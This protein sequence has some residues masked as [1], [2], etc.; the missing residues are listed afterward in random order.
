MGMGGKAVSG[1]APARADDVARGIA[2]TLLAIFLFAT[3]D[4]ASKL[5]VQDHSPFQV[6]MMRFWAFCAMSVVL[7]RRKGPF[8]GFFRSRSPKLQVLRPLLLVVDIWLFMFALATVPLAELQ[9]ITL[10]YPLIVTLVAI[11]LLG[12]KVGVFRF[13]AV[14]AGFVGALVIVRPGGLPLDFGALCGLASAACYAVYLVLTRKVAAVDPTETSLI[15][16]GVIGLVLTSAV[17][18]FFWQTPDAPTLGLL[19]YIMFTGCAG[20]GLI[21]AAL[22]AAPASVLQPF[23]YTALPWGILFGY[24]VF[25]QMIDPVSLG[26]A[27][28]IVA[29]GLAVMMRERWKRTTAAGLGRERA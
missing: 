23:N 29:A 22:G 19:F 13:S 20:H 21:I 27:A 11:P 5:L 7:A 15:Y 3:Q 10:I 4:A 28:L 24:A 8:R 2:F 14:L 16:V 9:A 18:V 6:A 26:G 25:G 1:E 17:G 12:E